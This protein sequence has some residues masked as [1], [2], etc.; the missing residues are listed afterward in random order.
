MEVRQTSRQFSRQI[1]VD[2]D[3]LR[4]KSLLFEVDPSSPYEKVVKDFADEFSSTSV[5][6]FTQRSGRVYRTLSSNERCAFFAFS[7]SV[8]YPKKSPDRP[9]EYL[10][11]H[12]DSAIYLDLMCKTLGSSE[13]DHVV[14][15]FDSISDM[16]VS[17][18]FPATYKF[19]KSAIEILGPNVTCL[20]L[21]MPSV[22]DTKVNAIIR[23]MFSN[24]MTSD[25]SNGI[26]LTKKP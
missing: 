4:G 20:F 1:G 22:H 9:N 7:T 24:H 6:V 25:N 14:F 21:A 23:S 26:R 13:N 3:F 18:G 5:H 11:P 8:S 17:A 16:I 10:V 12:N 2:T 19:L 15:V